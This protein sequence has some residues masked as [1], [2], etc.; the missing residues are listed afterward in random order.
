MYKIIK[1]NKISDS[2]GWFLKVLDGNEDYLKKEIGE[3]YV[4]VA[5]PN[6][7][8]GGHYHDIANEWFTLI[9]GKCILELYDTES[10]T[11]E[12]ITLSD[13]D[14]KTIYVPSK[15]AHRFL[16][17]GKENFTLLA[18]SDEKYDP[19]DTIMFDFDK[20]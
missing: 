6:K 18:Y 10:N 13:L 1:R 9:S 17:I 2:R 20:I 14:M 5:H 4:T 15:I 3:F 19:E 16:N 11:R 12:Q 7:F 8:K